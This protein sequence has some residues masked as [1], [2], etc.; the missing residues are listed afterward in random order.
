VYAI[1]I[2]H[3]TLT[4]EVKGTGGWGTFLT[5]PAG[6]VRIGKAGTIT[7]TVRPFSLAAKSS[8]LMNLQAVTL[9]PAGH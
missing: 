8:G 5:R 9:S 2:A 3:Q 4:G 7:I 1:E 6:K